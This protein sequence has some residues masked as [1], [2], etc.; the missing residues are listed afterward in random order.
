MKHSISATALGMYASTKFCKRCEWIRLHVKSI[1]YQSFPG[2]F[3]TIDRYN[4]LIVQSYIDRTDSL[5][6]WL[7]KLGQIESYLDP[8]HWSRFKVLDEETG[9]TLRGEADAIFKMSD[10]SYTIVDYKTAKYTAGQMGLFKNYEVQLNA[11]AFI[12]EHLDISPISQLAL[13]YMEPITDKE[14]VQTPNLINKLGFSIGLSATVIPVK[15]KTKKLIPPLLH[16]VHQLSE[17]KTP[18]ERI[19]ECKDCAALD[20]LVRSI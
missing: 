8:P 9:V 1:P 6:L 10:G 5:P 12:S 15:I 19:A 16:K 13:V 11:Y 17:M 2:I 18:P 3:S 7:S 14:T 4:K 20:N